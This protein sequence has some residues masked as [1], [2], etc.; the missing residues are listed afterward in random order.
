ME[1]IT[2]NIEYFFEDGNWIARCDEVGLVGYQHKDLNEVRG[3][4]KEGM[5]L[6]T[7]GLPFE[8]KELIQPA[9]NRTAV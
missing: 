6:H 9:G 5:L 7:G 3:Q 8:L 1:I 2:L 4:V